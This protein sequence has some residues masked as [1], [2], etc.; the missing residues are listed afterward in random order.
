MCLAKWKMTVL[1]HISMGMMSSL[2]C[3]RCFNSCINQLHNSASTEPMTFCSDTRLFLS[4]IVP[5]TIFVDH[6]FFANNFV[7]LQDIN[8]RFYHNVA[9]DICHIAF[10]FHYVQCTIAV[11]GRLVSGSLISCQTL[12]PYIYITVAVLLD[13]NIS[14]QYLYI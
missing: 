12:W 7:N 4:C 8:T 3:F 1:L 5:R 9:K 13:F 6:V 10:D 2:Y 14:V 11:Q